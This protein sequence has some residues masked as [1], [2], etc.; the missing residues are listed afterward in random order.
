MILSNLEQNGTLALDVAG[1]TKAVTMLTDTSTV[2]YSAY[3]TMPSGYAEWLTITVAGNVFSVTAISNLFG[4]SAR[5]VVVQF[6]CL[7]T[8][9]GTLQTTNVTVTQAADTVTLTFDPT[10]VSL[11]YTA[12][13]TDDITITGIPS[14][15]EVAVVCSSWL[16]ASMTAATTL[17]VI[18]ALN[19][20]EEARVGS[21]TVIIDSRPFYLTVTQAANTAELTFDPTAVSLAYTAGATD[22]IAVTG[23]PSGEEVTIVTPE[24]ITATLATG[25]LTVTALE[26]T[27]LSAR[28]GTVALTV[29]GRTFNL[30]VTQAANSY[31]YGP[32]TLNEV[33]HSVVWTGATFNISATAM[34]TNAIF[35]NCTAAATGSCVACGDTENKIG[36]VRLTDTSFAI[37]VVPQDVFDGVERSFV[38]HFTAG[39][40]SID[41]TVTQ[42]APPAVYRLYGA[43]DKFLKNATSSL[44]PSYT[45]NATVESVLAE[46]KSV[47]WLERDS[48]QPA[49]LIGASRD[50]I[51]ENIKSFDAFKVY[52]DRTLVGTA[53]LQ[54]V[55]MGAA[56][57]RFTFAAAAYGITLRGIRVNLRTDAYCA[58]GLRV[59]L[60]T[61]N[62]TDEPSND[63]SV[64]REGTGAKFQAGCFPRALNST[65]NKYY[66]SSGSVVFD[67]LAMTIDADSRLYLYVTME[68][69][70][71][72]ANGWVYGSGI[73]TPTFDF[74]VDELVSGVEALDT[75]ASANVPDEP[76]EMIVS[77][78][79]LP[80]PWTA[81]PLREVAVIEH[82]IWVVPPVP[83]HLTLSVY[84]QWV[85][86][87]GGQFSISVLELPDNYELFEISGVPDWLTALVNIQERT[88]SFSATPS[89]VGVPRSCD[90]TFSS[91][92][93]TAVL[94]VDQ[95]AEEITYLN[96]SPSS[97]S[98][99]KEG[100]TASLD[101]LSLPNGETAYT[102]TIMPTGATW[103]TKSAVAMAISVTAAAQAP[104]AAARSCSLR[105]VSGAATQNVAIQQEA[106]EPVT[107]LLLAQTSANA[108]Y[109][110]SSGA[111]AIL[112]LP[113]GQAIG[114]VTVDEGAAWLTVAVD[115][116]DH[117]VE[118]IASI[119]TGG[120][121]STTVNVLS[122]TET[123]SFVL[124]QAANPSALSVS[125]HSGTIGG[126]G[127]TLTAT[128][129]VPAGTP[130]FSGVSGL[131]G[132]I[133]GNVLT[134]TVAANTS[135]PRSLVGTVKLTILG[136]TS[137]A[138]YTV[139]QGARV[140]TPFTSKLARM[141][142]TTMSALVASTSVTGINGISISGDVCWVSGSFS[143][144]FGTHT[145]VCPIR[146]GTPDA[147]IPWN[148]ATAALI[149]SYTYNGWMSPRW[150]TAQYEFVGTRSGNA[151]STFTEISGQMSLEGSPAGGTYWSEPTTPAAVTGANRLVT[152]G[153]TI[154]S[155]C[156]TTKSAYKWTPV[157][158]QPSVVATKIGANFYA[159]PS[160]IVAVGS[161]V[162]VAGS[163]VGGVGVNLVVC[164]S[165]GTSWSAAVQSPTIPPASRMTPNDWTGLSM[166][167]VDGCMVVAGAFTSIGGNAVSYIA[168]WNGTNWVDYGSVK[169][170]GPVTAMC[171]HSSGLILAGN[172]TNYFTYTDPEPPPLGLE[173]E[174]EDP[175]PAVA[176]DTSNA[177]C[178]VRDLYAKAFDERI[179]PVDFTTIARASQQ[180]G[181]VAAL[182]REA[183][184]GS[185]ADHLWLTLSALLAHLEKPTTFSAS[186]IVV[187]TPTAA[188]LNL[189]PGAQ[190][191]L[192]AWWASEVYMDLSALAA[193]TSKARFWTGDSASVTGTNS[194]KIGAT[195]VALTA[196]FS[197]LARVKLDSGIWSLPEIELPIKDLPGTFGTLVLCAWLNVNGIRQIPA[198]EIFGV[199]TIDASDGTLTG[200]AGG[201]TP[202]VLLK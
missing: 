8:S 138:T 112:S 21:V 153:S 4:E 169:I 197:R 15:S 77:A 191:F 192:T 134:M 38:L 92:D 163:N 52:H 195:T 44:S 184:A 183:S 7:P 46:L 128:L 53:V 30:T 20:T 188:Q 37:T 166:S 6:A 154:F 71:G 148:A 135:A 139:Y 124:V 79:I 90:I 127:G 177:V 162:Y 98:F 56:V 26:N 171:A 25:T 80:A 84:N 182:K 85:N 107:H 59:A 89:E 140:V 160:A 27:A 145:G 187:T 158:G 31:Q 65:D 5:S 78:G 126:D 68:D 66:G 161:Y 114:G 108:A 125:P 198:E 181:I 87:T 202:R 122:G 199:G 118:W 45:V 141:T 17:T 179:Q 159:N 170:D 75:I 137:T 48:L 105:V 82:D 34:P 150:G 147:V 106:G 156:T 110:A 103:A 136:E 115:T 64:I 12:G 176:L 93:D 119:N 49:V 88:V 2:P 42:A 54:R 13:A 35:L 60:Q 151:Y 76:K 69:Y 91:G 33:S 72:V 165:S 102:A 200:A 94:H 113:N 40:E 61:T 41:L 11:A 194:V 121:R 63:W 18:A 3:Y 58:K 173:M 14:G 101:V 32:L 29:V 86:S 123:V 157:S 132:T 129:T 97:L 50:G 23:I 146:L 109:T 57:Y 120:Q 36:I 133:S 100:A 73:A 99:A 185:D 189:L 193:V 186:K 10:T 51:S 81:V 149:P 152:I 178:G 9:G 131:T 175:L 47:A 167:F 190:L 83:K 16:T 116:T 24:W 172:W 95:Q 144:L 130:T 1:E 143:N 155:I 74:F 142:P 96:V 67:G 70:S 19:E 201:W 22:D 55:S 174:M 62:E 111:I 196:A 180:Y 104:G 39:N 168:K 164:S 117:T 28:S 43:G